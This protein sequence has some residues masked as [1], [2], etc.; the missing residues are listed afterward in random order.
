MS[1]PSSLQLQLQVQGVLQ[2]GV[3]SSPSH[4]LLVGVVDGRLQLGLDK[5]ASMMLAP[6][7]RLSLSKGC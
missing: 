5:R 6:T 3:V 4:A 2:S 1:Y 7:K